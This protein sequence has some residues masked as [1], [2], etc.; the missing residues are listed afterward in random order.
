M[1][2]TEA[3]LHKIT[4]LILLA[5]VTRYCSAQDSLALGNDYSSLRFSEVKSFF[6][7]YELPLINC[8]S[9]DLFFESYCWL[10]TPYKYAGSSKSGIDCSGFASMLYEKIYGK[11]IS[12]GSRDM[13]SKCLIVEKDSIKEG[14]LIFFTIYRGEVSHVGV[15]LGNNKFVH[16][17]TQGGVMINDLNEPYYQKYF[18]KVGRL[19]KE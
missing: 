2:K 16:A 9:P 8:Q 12:G 1:A 19:E 7:K 10:G 15:Y 18:Y 13:I 5:F 14:D 17:T 4:I 6:D 3:S 11:A